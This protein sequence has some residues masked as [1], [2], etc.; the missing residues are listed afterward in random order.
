VWNA[1][2]QRGLL[3]LEGL[4]PPGAGQTY[5]LWLIDPKL[6]QPISG[7][8][9]PDNPGGSLRVQFSSPVRVETAE[10]FAISI[11]PRGGSVR[12]TRVI[13]SSN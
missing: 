11:E 12:P 4:P 7:G 5:Q 9:L 6:A 2:D 10:R 13:M 8:V 3:V 1:Q